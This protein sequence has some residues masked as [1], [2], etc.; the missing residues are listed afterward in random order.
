[1]KNVLVLITM[2]DENEVL[3]GSSVVDL[4]ELSEF[5]RRILDSQTYEKACQFAMGKL[6]VEAL[7]CV[8]GGA[9]CQE[10]TSL[11]V[12]LSV[13]RVY[14]YFSVDDLP[15]SIR[16]DIQEFLSDAEK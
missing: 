3:L 9:L 10:Y 5:I 11:D 14:E 13:K 15:K 8:D 7:Q 1:M 2:R 6:F 4:R 16:A 12:A